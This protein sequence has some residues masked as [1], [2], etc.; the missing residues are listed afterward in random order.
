MR[1]KLFAYFAGNLGDDMM[2]RLLLERYPNITFFAPTWAEESDIFRKFPNFE[3]MEVIQRRYGRMNHILNILFPFHRDFYLKSKLKR[4][5]KDCVCSVY[6]GGSVYTERTTPASEE[7]KL[8]GPPLFVIGAN[9]GRKAADFGDYFRRCAGVTFRDRVSY[10][11]FSDLPNVSYAPDVVLNFRGKSG[12]PK[13]YTL[14]NVMELHRP[15]LENWADRYEGKIAELCAHCE[16]PLLVSFCRKEGDEDAL[17]RVAARVPRAATYRYRGDLEE[18]LE[19][20]SGAETV[21]ATRLHAM[22]LAFCH[23]KPVAVFTYDEKIQN[24]AADMG[25]GCVYPISEVDNINPKELLSRCGLPENLEMFQQKAVEHF[26][27]LDL[28]L[29]EYHGTGQHYHPGV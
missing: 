4:I 23:Q 18:L 29:E 17:A 26:A 12:P 14:I 3:N 22:I 20:F 10:A 7:S 25:F 24:V 11:R 5:E 19:L 16:R 21:I 1:I 9:Y 13:G 2:V 15:G 8:D 6:I 27:K 28:F